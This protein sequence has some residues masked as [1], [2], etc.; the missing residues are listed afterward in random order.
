MQVR[1]A[2][3]LFCLLNLVSEAGASARPGL[4]SVEVTGAELTLG[5]LLP[6]AP[7]EFRDIE[8]GPTPGPGTSRVV[9]RDEVIAALPEGR[10]ALANGL[11]KSTRIVRKMRVLTND[12]IESLTKNAIDTRGLSRGAALI[13]VKAPKSV[14]IADGHDNVT[15]DIRK[16]PR[17]SGRFSTSATLSFFQGKDLLSKVIV[18]IDLQ[19]SKEAAIPDVTKG[20]AVTLVVQRGLIEISAAGVAGSDADIGSVLPITVRQSG[21]IIQARLIEKDRAVAVEGT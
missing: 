15:V 7:S 16:P 1:P 14:Q 21:R 5:A 10:Q 4:R 9:T 13:K 8:I 20:A 19:L 2:F 17:Q 3:A 18:P 11:A 12:E 6:N